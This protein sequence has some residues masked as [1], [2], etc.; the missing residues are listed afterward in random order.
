MQTFSYNTLLLNVHECPNE[1]NLRDLDELI[2]VVLTVKE[3]LLTKD[4]NE[5]TKL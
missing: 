4:L 1:A 3:R 5:S 2:I